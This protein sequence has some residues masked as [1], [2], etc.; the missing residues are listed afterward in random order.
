MSD[1]STAS[2]ASARPFA[3]PKLT[4]YHNT[5]VGNAERL[6]QC[7]GD[8]IRYSSEMD[9]WLVWSRE[10]GVWSIDRERRIENLAVQTV[11]RLALAANDLS[12]KDK[13]DTQSYARNSESDGAIRAML[14]RART[15]PAIQ[16]RVKHLDSNLQ[17]LNC[18]RGAWELEKEDGWR[19]SD[20]LDFCTQKSSVDPDRSVNISIWL[21]C[22][23]TAFNG[24]HAM[25]EYVRSILR[26]CLTGRTHKKAMFCFYGEPDSGKTTILKHCCEIWGDYAEYGMADT[27]LHRLGPATPTVNADLA[28]MMGKRLVILSEPEK[29]IPFCESLTKILTSNAKITACFKGKNP[30]TFPATAKYILEANSLPPVSQDKASW[31][32]FHAIPFLNSIPLENQ[33]DLDEP[34]RQE[35]AGILAWILDGPREL[36]E[37]PEVARRAMHTWKQ[38]NYL[39]AHFSKECLV[40]GAE[41]R[42]SVAALHQQFGSW[43][44]RTG[45]RTNMRQLSSHLIERGCY[46]ER[47]TVNGKQSWFWYG[48]TVRQFSHRVLSSFS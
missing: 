31:R 10:E 39:A 30:F 27:L 41:A 12:G 8:I 43:K 47:V 20:P 36:S 17:L 28:R 46:R 32:R 15:S 48:V 37:P 40:F 44:S 4:D 24:S 19:E 9:K 13:E 29:G 25:I 18:P 38:E 2:S 22:L 23:D 14:S 3:M 1:S 33:L 6:V 35:H 7:Y 11:R 5:D 42:S 21:D 16:L 45:A 26:Y 34:L